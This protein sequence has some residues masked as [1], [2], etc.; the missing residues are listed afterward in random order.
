MKYQDLT[1]EQQQIAKN[2]FVK[3]LIRDMGFTASQA[4]SE[5]CLI[6]VN[7]VQMNIG[8]YLSVRRIGATK[9]LSR[10][11]R[12]SVYA[13]FENALNHATF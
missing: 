3:M 2:T 8:N 10:A 1:R 4:T 11:D 6:V 5:F 9:M 13:T 7:N 12:C